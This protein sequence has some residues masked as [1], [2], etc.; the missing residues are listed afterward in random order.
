VAKAACNE[1]GLIHP[2]RQPKGLRACP[3]VFVGVCHFSGFGVNLSLFPA[4]LDKPGTEDR[5]R[6]LFWITLFAVMMGTFIDGD[7]LKGSFSHAWRRL[8]SAITCYRR[9]PEKRFRLN[10][11]QCVDFGSAEA[12]LSASMAWLACDEVTLLPLCLVLCS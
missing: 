12:W 4:V 10:D 1:R 5:N 9:M 6:T 3:V 2:R 8:A 11:C 7:D